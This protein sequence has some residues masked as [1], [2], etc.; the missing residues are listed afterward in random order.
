VTMPIRVPQRKKHGA[1]C[2]M[3]K[4]R[5]TNKQGRNRRDI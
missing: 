4:V 1:R 3:P 5:V 2:W